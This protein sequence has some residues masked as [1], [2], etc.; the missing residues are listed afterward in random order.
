MGRTSRQLGRRPGRLLEIPTTRETN[1]NIVAFWQP[2][3]G[4]RAGKP[5]RIAYRLHWSTDPVPRSGVGRIVATRIGKSFD[6]KRRLFVI[7]IEGAGV[8]SEGLK[9]A[10]SSSAGKVANP[11]IQPNPVINGLRASFELDTD[12]LDLAELRLVVMKNGKAA[13]ETWL[14]RWTP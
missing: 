9:L 11:V 8:S 2:R 14:Y 1:D 5:F 7:D 3:G 4:L 12:D 6:G 10:L 13:S